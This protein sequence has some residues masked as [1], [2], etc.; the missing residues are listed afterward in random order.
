MDIRKILTARETIEMD[1]T[2]LACAPLTRVMAAAVIRNPFAGEHGRDLPPLF[3]IAAAVG[4]RLSDEAAALLSRPATGYG[5]AALVG[6]SGAMEHGAAVLHPTLGKPLRAAIG[7]GAALIP[8]NRKVAT[9]GTAIDIPLGQM[10]DAWMF[11]HIDTWTVMIAD[12]PRTDEIAIFV[13][14]SDGRRPYT[15]VGSGPSSDPSA[16]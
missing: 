15:R 3:A 8:A 1:E 7:G 11:D 9:L 5:K 13:A 10:D 2:G 4:E 6:A 12:A 16:G 14:L